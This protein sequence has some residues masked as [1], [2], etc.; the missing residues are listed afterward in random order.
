MGHCKIIAVTGVDT[1][2]LSLSGQPPS[3]SGVQIHDQL[4]LYSEEMSYPCVFAED[5]DDRYEIF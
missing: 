1:D 4:T 5:I 3:G 2:L